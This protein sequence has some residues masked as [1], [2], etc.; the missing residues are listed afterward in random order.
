MAPLYLLGE[1]LVLSGVSGELLVAPTGL[2][3]FWSLL[4][5]QGEPG[6]LLHVLGKSGERLLV[7]GA[8]QGLTHALEYTA[9]LLRVL[10]EFLEVSHV[11]RDSLG[12]LFVQ[13]AW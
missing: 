8:L 12:L 13:G 4:L 6:R 3:N 10:G 11:L 5:V 7:Q 9:A 1:L 2:P